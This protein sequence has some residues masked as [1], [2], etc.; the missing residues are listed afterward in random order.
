MS[1]NKIKVLKHK[2][3]VSGAYKGMHYVKIRLFGSVASSY[4]FD[5]QNALQYAIANIQD[6]NIHNRGA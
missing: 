1:Y 6:R 4:G 2:V 3:M 5:Y